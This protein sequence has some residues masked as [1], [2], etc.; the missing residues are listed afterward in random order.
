MK[1]GFFK[2]SLDQI[3]KGIEES[4]QLE[5][6]IANSSLY[7]QFFVY[8][9]PD[10]DEILNRFR[11]E[12]NVDETQRGYLAQYINE[13]SVDAATALVLYCCGSRFLP[14]NGITMRNMHTDAIGGQTCKNEF[15]LPAMQSY[16]QFKMYVN[17]ILVDERQGRKTTSFNAF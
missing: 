10:K 17:A 1:V 8:T 7:R 13:I 5:N 4:G 2:A 3:R 15:I 14:H 6:V 12:N 9:A 16:A 11:Y